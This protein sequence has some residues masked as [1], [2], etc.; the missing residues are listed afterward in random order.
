LIAAL[1]KGVEP[2][3]RSHI[4]VALRIGVKPETLRSVFV[5]TEECVG[6]SEA[7]AGRKLLN[8]IL[9]K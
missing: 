7:D 1:G 9:G 2:M 3:L 5:L 4:G 8:E 6:K